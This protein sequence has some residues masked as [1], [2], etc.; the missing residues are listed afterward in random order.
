[1]DAHVTVQIAFDITPACGDP[2]PNDGVTTN[3]VSLQI[4][5]ISVTN[6]DGDVVFDVILAIVSP[7][8]EIAQGL[9]NRL[10]A[11]KDAFSNVVGGLPLCPTF[12]VD[13]G[14]PAGVEIQVDPTALEL[15]ALAGIDLSICR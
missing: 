1:L 3:A 10:D 13:S 11:V 6:I 2:D 8:S 5:P 12:A 4:S 9:N 7:E 15:A 14:S